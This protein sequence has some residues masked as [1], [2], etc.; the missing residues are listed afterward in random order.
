[1]KICAIFY[2][3]LMMGGV[4]IFADVHEFQVQ[5]SPFAHTHRG[6]IGVSDNRY[7]ARIERYNR[8]RRCSLIGLSLVN[9]N[10]NGVDLT[11]SVLDDADLLSAE[12]DNAL[13]ME[14]SMDFVRLSFASAIGA[15]FR[16]AHMNHADVEHTILTRANLSGV[17]AVQ[18]SFIG[19]TAN[20]VNF[21]K[22][23]FWFAN[24]Q[25]ADLARAI[26]D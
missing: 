7:V 14:T 25:H 9:V 17:Q 18:V 2:L 6:F 22:G 24:M 10:W 23:T 3:V 12:L 13:L 1:M 5:T 16:N 4:R 21:S 11:G 20:K 19:A 26:F 8:C 15:D